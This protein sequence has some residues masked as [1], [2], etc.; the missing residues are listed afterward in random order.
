MSLKETI[1]DLLKFTQRE[2]VENLMG[3]LENSDYFT[4]PS[5]T[6]FHGAHE[7]GLAEHSFSVYELLKEKNKRYGNPYP[8]ESVVI[9]G[10]LHDLCKVNFY[11]RGRKNVKENGRWTEKEVWMVDDD[12]PLGHGEKSVIM[13]QDYIKLTDLEKQAIRWHMVAFD[14]GIHFNYPSGFAFRKASEKYPA[15]VL[16]FTADYESSYMIEKQGE[17]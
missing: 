5:S 7:G 10:L 9:C 1:M 13:I 2:G 6:M 16:L 4:A 8:D 11:K 12:M 15:I 14:A 3:F 17:K